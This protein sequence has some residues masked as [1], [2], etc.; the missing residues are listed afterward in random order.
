MNFDNQQFSEK[1][2][3]G[4]L[5]KN[6]DLNTKNPTIQTLNLF[7]INRV[8]QFWVDVIE[9]L[10]QEGKFDGN[11]I[12]WYFEI[13]KEGIEARKVGANPFTF[14]EIKEEC[15]QNIVN[16]YENKTL[17]QYIELGTSFLSNSYTLLSSWV[18]DQLVLLRLE[19]IYYSDKPGDWIKRAEEEENGIMKK[20]SDMIPGLMDVINNI[21]L[22]MSRRV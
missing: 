11:K 8:D 16:F 19:Y 1:T 18:R 14:I 3:K 22:I 5:L 7:F 6:I 10:R 21:G 17:K 20:Q 4:F 9:P 12:N 2:L 13:Y 15:I